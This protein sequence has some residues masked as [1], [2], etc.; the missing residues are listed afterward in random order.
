M[1]AIPYD[2]QSDTTDRPPERPVRVVLPTV[3]VPEEEVR[4]TVGVGRFDNLWVDISENHR[5]L[6]TLWIEESRREKANSWITRFST[7]LRRFRDLPGDWSGHG[8]AAPNN[9]AIVEAS[10]VLEILWSEFHIKPA[11][12]APSLDEGV[13]IS[14][15]GAHGRATIECFNSGEIVASVTRQGEES[16]VW[17][18]ENDRAE[19]CGEMAKLV[20]GIKA[21]PSA[22]HVSRGSTPRSVVPT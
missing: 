11:R 14:I 20:Y 21:R 12:I 2:I 13:L 3:L 17:E 6:A 18:V 5:V 1:T 7:E 19:L 16:I 9:A 22:A 15:L 10:A 4:A 8:A